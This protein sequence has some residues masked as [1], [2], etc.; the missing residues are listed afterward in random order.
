MYIV[1]R[2]AVHVSEHYFA[3]LLV[4]AYNKEGWFD[5]QKIFQLF[6]PV[7]V[8]TECD[9]NKLPAQRTVGWFRDKRFDACLTEDV[10][11]V[12]NGVAIGV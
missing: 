11:A 9:V 5:G 1:F 4:V 8:F 2:I 6:I 10:S 3:N 12:Q 7:S